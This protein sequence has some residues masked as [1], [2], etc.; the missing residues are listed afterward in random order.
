MEEDK[1]SIVRD[2]T[3]PA[4]SVI[5][6]LSVDLREIRSCLCILLNGRGLCLKYESDRRK[7]LSQSV[8]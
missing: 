5:L 3:I 8:L 2:K 1:L 4:S 6:L 7:T